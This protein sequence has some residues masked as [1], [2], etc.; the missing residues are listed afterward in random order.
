VRI[1]RRDAAVQDERFRVEHG[2]AYSG[3]RT[4]GAVEQWMPPPP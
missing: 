3:S 1:H 4:S 2:A